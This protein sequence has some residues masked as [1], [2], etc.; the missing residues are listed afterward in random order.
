MIRRPPRSTLFPY[1]TLFR[2]KA[3]YNS[4][5]SPQHS[6]LPSPFFDSHLIEDAGRVAPVLLDLDEEFEVDAVPDQAFDVAARAR[7]Y[8]AQ[9]LAAAAY[10]YFFLRGALDVNRAVDARE[11]FR[12]LFVALRDDS[13]DVRNLLARD[14]QD[15]LADEFGDDDAHGLIC[16]FVLPKNRIAFGE[17]INYF[18]DEV[19]ELVAR[20]RRERQNGAPLILARV[21]L[22]ERQKLSLVFNLIRLVEQ[23]YRRLLGL[24][25]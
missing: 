14:L 13:R 2:S 7:A 12:D 19:F 15:F 21:P 23:Q 9:T 5:L 25:D 16:E 4:V 1:T 20:P 8:L 24:F 3:D 17:V 6:V 22:D 18:F 11:F 10:D